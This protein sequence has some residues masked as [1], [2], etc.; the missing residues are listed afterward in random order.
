M[1]V[2]IL[3]TSFCIAIALNTFSQAGSNPKTIDSLKT[4]I[5][6]TQNDTVR[7]NTYFKLD[8]LIYVTNPELDLEINTTV[9]AFCEKKLASKLN[10]KL[11]KFYQRKLAFSLNNLGIIAMYK[12]DYKRAT[13]Y[14]NQTISWGKKS[15]DIQKVAVAYS[16]LGMLHHRQ[17]NLKKAIEYYLNGLQ[18]LEVAKDSNGIA[19]AL[20]NIGS[21]YNTIG[22]TAKAKECCLKSLAISTKIGNKIWAANS[23]NNLAE[24]TLRAGDYKT[25][26]MYYEKSI[27]LHTDMGNKQGVA[28]SYGNYGTYY[29]IQKDFKKALENYEKSH[30]LMLEAGDM[31]GAAISLN[32]MARAHFQLGNYK[33]AIEFSTQAYNTLTQ[34]LKVSENIIVVENLYNAYKKTGDHRNALLM[35][36]NYITLRDSIK[37]NENTRSIIEKQYQYDYDKKLL[38]DSVKAI[39]AEK[40]RTA[41][42]AK[43][44]AEADKQKQQ[45]YFSYALLALALIFGAFIYNRFQLANKQKRIIEEQKKTVDHAYVELEEKNK[46]ILDSITYAK[47]I[48]GAILPPQ[49]LVKEYLHESFILY[50]PK[51]IVAGD[52]YWLE[53]IQLANEQISKLANEGGKPNQLIL[54]AAAD[55][56]GHGVPGA[57]VS[58]VCHNALNR[59]VRE[60]GIVDPGKILDKTRE[61]VIQEFEKSD[62]EV[63]DGMD[64]SLCCLEISE[65][66]KSEIESQESENGKIETASLRLREKNT[67]K[68]HWSGANNPL[69]IIRDNEII[70]YSPD[71][72]PIGKFMNAKPFQTHT[73]QLQ[74]NDAVYVFTDGYA[75]QFG[76]QHGKKYKA[77]ALKKILLSLQDQPMEKQKEMLNTAFENWRGNLEQ[78]DDVCVIGVKI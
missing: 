29:F 70:E 44:K 42:S 6:T 56:T 43:Q 39:E 2:K 69:W 48:Q 31:R 77:S 72:Q 3:L 58:V 66:K 38:A 35:L 11:K 49:R 60:Y 17:G 46:E 64:I 65:N 34:M 32:S 71:K 53:A 24:Y 15:G 8:D 45:K 57:M 61:I 14:F 67:Y 5:A 1:R 23:Y 41:E 37:N 22:D 62:E 76:G 33:K 20:N 26:L 63:K 9:K 30:K 18:K 74:K 47:R 59:S 4:I 13:H 28:L 7:I 27:K 40:V 36:E 12:S 73:V 10:P 78:V 55:C 75:D 51:D 52:F 16:N 68:L 25:T 50:K 54:F 19:G 21:L